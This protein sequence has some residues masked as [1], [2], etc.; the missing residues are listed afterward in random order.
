MG[1]NFGIRYNV[2]ICMCIDATGSMGIRNIL[3]RAYRA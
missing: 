1:S 3:I 2:D